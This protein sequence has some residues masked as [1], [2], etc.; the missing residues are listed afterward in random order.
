MMS[1]FTYDGKNHWG[2]GRIYDPET[3]KTYRCKLTLDSDHKLEVRGYI[4]I[5]LLGR[6]MVWTR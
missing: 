2:G 5:S 4:G 3:G 6:T 1:H